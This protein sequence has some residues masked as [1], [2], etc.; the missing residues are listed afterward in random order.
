MEI[1]FKP[2]TLKTLVV[3]WWD[4]RADCFPWR[5]STWSCSQELSGPCDYSSILPPPKCLIKKDLMRYIYFPK[6]WRRWASSMA[7]EAENVALWLLTSE[8]ENNTY[9]LKNQAAKALGTLKMMAF[10]SMLSSTQIKTRS[11]LTAS[12][13][14]NSLV[15]LFPAL[16]MAPCTSTKQT[17]LHWHLKVSTCDILWKREVPAPYKVLTAKRGRNI[18]SCTQET[19]SHSLSNRRYF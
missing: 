11:I 2:L 19:N 17:D 16:R 3:A 12:Q 13:I 7:S 5:T 15:S 6:I 10:D 9:F 18:N 4:T 1:A 14:C 8:L